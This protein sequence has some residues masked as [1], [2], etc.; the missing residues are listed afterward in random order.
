MK[1]YF[2]VVVKFEFQ[3]SGNK[4]FFRYLDLRIFLNDTHDDGKLE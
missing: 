3:R 4:F 1:H 2:F